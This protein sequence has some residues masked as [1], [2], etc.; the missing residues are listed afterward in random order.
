MDDPMHT[1]FSKSKFEN[2]GNGDFRM[3]KNGRSEI[4]GS[5]AEK[6]DSIDAKCTQVEVQTEIEETLVDILQ[7]GSSATNGIEKAS[8]RF[9]KSTTI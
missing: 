7:L 5:I 8:L 3:M 1:I 6:A 2:F 9:L 4:M